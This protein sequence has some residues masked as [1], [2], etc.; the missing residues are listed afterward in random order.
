MK[1]VPQAKQIEYINSLYLSSMPQ[2]LTRYESLNERK[3]LASGKQSTYRSEQMAKDSTFS[4]THVDTV[5]A[6]LVN[7]TDQKTLAIWAISCV[8]RVL[9][10]FEV[11]YP[12]DK[13]PADAI[14][15]LQQ[16]IQTGIFSMEV[17]RKASLDAHGAAR[18]VGEDNAARS[19]ARAAGQAV[20]TAHVATHSL[21]AAKYALQAIYRST[22]PSESNVAVAEER[23]WQYQQLQN[24]NRKFGRVKPDADKKKEEEQVP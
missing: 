2:T 19:A 10:Y 3:V 11:Q 14:K 12:H 1:I 6:E 15:T 23:D 13:R 18:D 21:A 17:I 9:P 24:L 22:E 8:E 20:A 16:W 4:L 5:M 7:K